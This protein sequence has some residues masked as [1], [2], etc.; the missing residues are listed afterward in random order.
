MTLF[1][2][3]SVMVGIVLALGVSHLLD[4][5]SRILRE[6]SLRELDP[7]FSVWFL[8]QIGVHFEVWWA[9]W[10]YRELAVWNYMSFLYVITGPI[11]LV[12]NNGFLVPSHA[13]LG[14]VS[15][16]AHF[17]AMKTRI[18]GVWLLFMAWSVLFGP[19][20]ADELAGDVISQVAMLGLVL[21]TLLSRSRRVH[22]WAGVSAILFFAT[23]ILSTRFFPG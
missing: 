6:R 15:L 4:A 17:L 22:L 3:V 21:L 19:V 10:S 5:T 23:V 1:E 20:V 16:E 12:I 8:I 11:L 13:E 14:S 2:Y 18:M 9:L 7:L